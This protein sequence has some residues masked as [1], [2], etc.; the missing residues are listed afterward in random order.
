MR[1]TATGRRETL[2]PDNVNAVSGHYG[3]RAEEQER[4]PVAVCI[5]DND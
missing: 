2:E 4:K 3:D 5:M 1:L